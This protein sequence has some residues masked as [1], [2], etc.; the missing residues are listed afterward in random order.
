[1]VVAG[2][3]DF[4]IEKKKAGGRGPG[5]DFVG[6]DFAKALMESR[7]SFHVILLPRYSS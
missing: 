4:L 5:E 1:M 6:Y 3:V 7:R 2:S